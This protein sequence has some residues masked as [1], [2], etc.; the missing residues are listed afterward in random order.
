VEMASGNICF[1]M[2]HGK[3]FV[4]VTQHMCEG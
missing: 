2:T 4:G 1:Q 3:K